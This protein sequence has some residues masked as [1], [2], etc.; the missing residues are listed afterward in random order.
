MLQKNHT[1]LFRH[2]TSS[3]CT[4][5][6][7]EWQVAFNSTYLYSHLNTFHHFSF[8]LLKI[9]VLGS[10]TRENWKAQGAEG[11]T[12]VDVQH[13]DQSDPSGNRSIR[14]YNPQTGKIDNRQKIRG[15]FPVHKSAQNLKTLRS[16]CREPELEEHTQAPLGLICCWSGTRT[17]NIGSTTLAVWEERIISYVV[18]MRLGI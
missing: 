9:L 1:V 5:L 8:H 16:H 17:S 12:R 14:T 6:F 2:Y 11:T 18:C 13:K 7:L 15:L 10:K 4:A 3:R